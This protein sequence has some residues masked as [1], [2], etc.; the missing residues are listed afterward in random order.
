MPR[1]RVGNIGRKKA[2]V[3]PAPDV[4]NTQWEGKVQPEQLFAKT[5]VN[6]DRHS[7][8]T[9]DPNNLLAKRSR[10]DIRKKFYSVRVAGEWNNLDENTKVSRTV[11]SFKNTINKPHYTGREVE[12]PRR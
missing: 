11:A 8:F 6:P 2:E 12:G 7:R 5:G 1:T 9:A 4:Q 3:G 10:L